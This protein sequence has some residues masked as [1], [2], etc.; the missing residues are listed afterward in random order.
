MTL[1]PEERFDTVLYIDVLE[2]IEDNQTEVARVGQD[3]IPGGDLVV[4]ARRTRRSI[5]VRCGDRACPALR[6]SALTDRRPRERAGF[7]AHA[8]WTASGCSP[9][10]AIGCCVRRS[11]TGDRSASGT[12]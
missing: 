6:H 9:C 7:A 12:D 1:G 8:I 4:L 11:Q 3:L 2:H 5:P 10:S